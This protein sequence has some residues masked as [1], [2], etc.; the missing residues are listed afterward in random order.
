M[1]IHAHHSIVTHLLAHP[2][3][4]D[5]P[6]HIDNMAARHIEELKAAGHTVTHHD[7][8]DHNAEAAAIGAAALVAG[9]I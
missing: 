5:H 1:S 6:H 7:V 4:E 3:P 9:G 8:H 2:H